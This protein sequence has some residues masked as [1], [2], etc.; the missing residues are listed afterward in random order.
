[1]VH[2]RLPFNWKTPVGYSIVLAFESIV[3][4]SIGL[5]CVPLISFIVGSCWLTNSFVKDIAS[6]LINFN[7]KKKRG[8]QRRAKKHLCKVIN[9][10]ADAKQ[11][12][13]PTRPLLQLP[14]KYCNFVFWIFKIYWNFSLKTNG[15][16]HWIVWLFYCQFIHMVFS[17][18][19]KFD[20]CLWISWVYYCIS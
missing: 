5:T 12:S 8:T 13:K 4:S 18:I 9:D 7:V 11:L 1:M 10:F 16:D 2:F 15:Y 19:I 17:Y 14:L 6:D 3:L 20:V